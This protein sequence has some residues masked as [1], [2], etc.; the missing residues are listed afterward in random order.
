M[1]EIFPG[2]HAFL[3]TPFL[4]ATLQIWLIFMVVIVV[5]ISFFREWAPPDV[6][7]LCA[8]GISFLFVLDTD[9]M[10]GVFSNRAPIT[11]ACMFVLSA[12]LERTGAIDIMG[13]FFQRIAGKTELRVMLTLMLIAAVL[14][15]FVNN[16]PVVVVFLPIVNSLA[17][18]LGLNA[19][20]LLIPLSFA[21]I[22]GGTCTLTGTS[23]NLII[24][25]LYSQYQPDEPAF[26][27]FEMT[28]I[29]IIYA[30]IGFIYLGTIGRKLLP[31]RKTLEQSVEPPEKRSFLTQFSV[32]E[33]SPL[34]GK[35][36]PETLLSEIPETEVL[37]VRRRGRVLQAPLD[38]LK[39]RSG[40]RLLI[41]LHGTSFED[42]K[43]TEGIRFAYSNL[44]LKQLETRELKLMEGIVG[45]QSELVGHTLREVKFRQKF[46]V[47]I[48][49][50]HRMGR[51][52]SS[53]KD[54]GNVKLD[55]G[56]TLLIEG[57]VD[58]I[59]Q[60]QR[61]RNFVSLNEPP[62][63][64]VRPKGLW[65]SVS[66]VLL[67]ILGAAL[68]PPG[69]P[70]FALL[71][72]VG[73]IL[74]RCLE[75]QAAYQSV[76]WSIVFLIFGMLALGKAM[77][78][79][80]AAAFFASGVTGIFGGASPV[81][82]LSIVYLL[83][84]VLTELISNNAVAAL[85]TPIVIGIAAELQVDARP[86]IVALMLGCSASFATPIGYQTNTYVYGAGGYRFSD[87]PKIGIPL[88][89]TLWMVA[90]ILV[91]ILWKFQP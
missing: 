49:A 33:D 65:I 6:I 1:P 81:V 13:D 44:S 38:R 82:I 28:K 66:L 23:T 21:S 7:A 19:S 87:F 80:G 35:T 59:N 11:I 16:T 78:V 48:L 57:P 41:T 67:F 71:A 54:L 8:L 56:D 10:L 24:A 52:L 74:S 32:E 14:S 22:L 90:T 64:K 72:A 51:D 46:G 43:E 30:A 45:P 61:S 89:L 58:A 73:M 88:N 62:S 50:V 63:R 60:L 5:A 85:L 27:M 2:Y 69:I 86:F 4:G 15:A 29:G 83:S 37:E 70:A 26:G 17:K 12:A 36:L 40:D 42:L 79:S 75:P 18:N 68:F 76:Q 47:H 39:I 84:S 9:Q 55:F 3:Q 25:D 77:E 20:R 34:V 91:P 53:R 31:Q